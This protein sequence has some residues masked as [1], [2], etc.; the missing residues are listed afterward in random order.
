MIEKF[1]FF[2][3]EILILRSELTKRESMLEKEKA[4][5]IKALNL[6]NEELRDLETSKVAKIEAV[7]AETEFLRQDLR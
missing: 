2:Q 1:H 7:K 6:K 5:N 3:G 4:D